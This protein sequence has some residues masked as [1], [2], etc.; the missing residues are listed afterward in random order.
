MLLVVNT[1]VKVTD[2]TA[3]DKGAECGRFHFLRPTMALVGFGLE[4]A[5]KSWTAMEALLRMSFP[6]GR[7]RE[8]E[9]HYWGLSPKKVQWIWKQMILPRL[10]WLSRLGSFSDENSDDIEKESCKTCPSLLCPH[11]ENHT[12]CRFGDHFE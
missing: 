9:K 3:P 7:P 6:H 5:V 8:S 10:T 4:V 2:L 1:A 12:Y 11:V